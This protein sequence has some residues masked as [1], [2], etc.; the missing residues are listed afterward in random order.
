MDLG[1]RI[2][3]SI[4]KLYIVL[5]GLERK[6]Y[7]GKCFPVSLSTISS[8]FAILLLLLNQRACF[9]VQDQWRCC[10]TSLVFVGLEGI[11]N[12]FLCMQRLQAGAHICRMSICNM[13]PSEYMRAHGEMVFPFILELDRIWSCCNFFYSDVFTFTE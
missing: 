10:K 2:I 6:T 12:L 1:S 8:V 9:F 3:L 4:P 7:A 11:R 5:Q 13:Y